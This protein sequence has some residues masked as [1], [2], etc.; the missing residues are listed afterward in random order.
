VPGSPNASMY[1]ER[2]DHIWCP[3]CRQLVSLNMYAGP[4]LNDS[5]LNHNVLFLL[6]LNAFA[7]PQLKRLEPNWSYNNAL[8][9]GANIDICHSLELH[10]KYRFS[11]TTNAFDLHVIIPEPS[12]G[13]LQL[14]I[15][16]GYTRF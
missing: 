16:D 13:A 11:V 8:S 4:G 10:T 6:L 1:D 3:D 14:P 7:M 9:T 12:A 2:M 15:V 5:I